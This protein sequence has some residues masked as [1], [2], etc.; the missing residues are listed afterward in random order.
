MKRFKILLVFLVLMSGWSLQ[1]QDIQITGT[2]SGSD[3]RE[4]LPGVS[5]VVKG[6]TTGT[7]TD[8]NGKY[9]LNVPQ[10]AQTLVFSSVGYIKEEIAING[11]TTIDVI[12]DPELVGLDEVVVTAMGIKRSEKTL[13]YAATTVS[14]DELV[15]DRQTNVMNSLSGKVA[16]LQVSSP[17][18][19]PGSASTVT[20]RGFGSINGSNEPLYVIDGVPLQTTTIETS[21][22]AISA[23]GITNIPS[24]DI[25]SMTVLKGAAATALYGSR[26]SNGVIVITTKKGQKGDGKNFT[27]QYN[28]GVKLRQVSVFPELQNEFGQGWNGNQTYIE[29]GSWGPRLDG[30]RQVYGPIWN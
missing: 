25:E 2:V 17:S 12:L 9:S 6:T 14:N 3:T 1:A 27:V 19:D 10:N 7:S 24:N 8:I 26:A 22:H 13:G 28:G 23:G 4:P 18:S 29:N 20:I 30:S 16:G 5:V 21:G 11:Q 15:K